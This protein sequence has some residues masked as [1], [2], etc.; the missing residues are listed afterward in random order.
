MTSL[1][2]QLRIF[3]LKASVGEETFEFLQKHASQA[4]NE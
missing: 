2:E 4:S 3:N 1:S